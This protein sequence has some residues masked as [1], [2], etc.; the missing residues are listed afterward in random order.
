MK[1]FFIRLIKNPMIITLI[2]LNI[3]YFAASILPPIIENY[4]IQRLDYDFSV[5]VPEN[6]TEQKWLESILF[7]YDGYADGVSGD[8]YFEKSKMYY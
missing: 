7:Y 1:K 6:M 8:R 2:V 4:K 3:A 5:L